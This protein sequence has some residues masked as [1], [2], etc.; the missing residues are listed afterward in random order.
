[1]HNIDLQMFSYADVALVDFR[2]QAT[3]LCPH[4]LYAENTTNVIYLNYI[5]TNHEF[6]F[7]LYNCT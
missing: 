2:A 1:M 6:G 3:P 7:W 4:L 5:N